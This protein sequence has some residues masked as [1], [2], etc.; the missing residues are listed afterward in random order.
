AGDTMYSPLG[1][2]TKLQLTKGAVKL[3]RIEEAIMDGASTSELASLS[4]LYYPE[5]PHD[6]ARR[7]PAVIS[8]LPQLVKELGLLITFYMMS[9][10]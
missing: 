9:S 2:L 5:I 1:H 8:G 4:S 10:V 7:P 6:F 3:T